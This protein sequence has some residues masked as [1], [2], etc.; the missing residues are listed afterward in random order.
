MRGKLSLNAFKPAYKK[1]FYLAFIINDTNYAPVIVCILLFSLQPGFGWFL[2]E[3]LV[4]FSYILI[5]IL[6]IFFHLAILMWRRLDKPLWASSLHTSFILL[7]VTFLSVNLFHYFCIICLIW[8]DL[9]K[10]EFQFEIRNLKL[11]N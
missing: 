11:R 7:K 4:E 3:F 2:V 1:N 10:F 8:I 5:I 6:S 9:N